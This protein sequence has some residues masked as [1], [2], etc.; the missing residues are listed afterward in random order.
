LL[1]HPESASRMIGM[2]TNV[3]RSIQLPPNSH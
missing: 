3:F 2:M 1:L